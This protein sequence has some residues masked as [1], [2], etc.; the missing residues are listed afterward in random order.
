[1]FKKT[2]NFQ[3]FFFIL[4]LTQEDT[5][6]N[7]FSSEWWHKHDLGKLYVQLDQKKRFREKRN[8]SFHEIHL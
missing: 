8:R 3:H 2:K 1:L 7:I 5:F 4:V 6:V